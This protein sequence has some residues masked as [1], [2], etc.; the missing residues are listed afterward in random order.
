MDITRKYEN[1]KK[2][3][4][5]MLEEIKLLAVDAEE[6]VNETQAFHQ[7]NFSSL[8]IL[9]RDMVLAER[10]ALDKVSDA[11]LLRGSISQLRSNLESEVRKL[12]RNAF[13]PT[14]R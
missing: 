2:R 5:L 13:Q 4:E 1:A 8:D 9:D 10:S 11:S 14:P 3:I 6:I 7:V 12:E